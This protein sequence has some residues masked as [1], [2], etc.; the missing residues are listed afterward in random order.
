VLSEEQIGHLRHFDN[1][2][3]QLPNDWSSMQGKGIGQDDFGG[4]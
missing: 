1:L 3:R 2:S 4:F